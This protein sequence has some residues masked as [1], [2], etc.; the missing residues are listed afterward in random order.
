MQ[1]QI[2]NLRLWGGVL[3]W[4]VKVRRREEMRSRTNTGGSPAVITPGSEVGHYA[5]ADMEAVGEQMAARAVTRRRVSGA[6]GSIPAH[7]L[8]YVG[9]HK[10]MEEVIAL[11]EAIKQDMERHGGTFPDLELL[12]RVAGEGSSGEGDEESNDRGKGK[13]ARVSKAKPSQVKKR[14]GTN[15]SERGSATTSAA[16]QGNKGLQQQFGTYSISVVSVGSRNATV[17]IPAAIDDTHHTEESMVMRP[18]RKLGLRCEE[19]DVASSSIPEQAPTAL[20]TRLR[21]TPRSPTKR[22]RLS[23]EESQENLLQNQDQ[24]TATPPASAPSVSRRTSLAAECTAPSTCLSYTRLEEVD[25]ALESV[26]VTSARIA[27]H[28]VEQ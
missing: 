19:V 18:K 5:D 27:H 12:P 21:E 17:P 1:T 25:A 23:H 13:R 24:Q 4:T 8:Q 7:Y 28:S 15:A 6:G 11:V 26:R 9:E 14:R 3:D 10:S 22:R 20:V 2:N 16:E